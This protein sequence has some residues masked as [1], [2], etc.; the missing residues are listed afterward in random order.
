M[1]ELPAD[2][3]EKVVDR[4]VRGLSPERIYLFGSHA[5]GEPGSDS[6]LFVVISSS[7]LPRHGGKPTLLVI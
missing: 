4:L 1:K 6:D 2:L 3:L 7:D 5:Y